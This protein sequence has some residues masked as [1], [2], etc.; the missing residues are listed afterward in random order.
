MTNFHIQDHDLFTDDVAITFAAEDTW[1]IQSG[2]LV[3]SHSQSAIFSGAANGTLL[4]K[5]TILSGSESEAGVFFNGPNAFI[6]NAAGARIVG[7]SDGV[8]TNS[9]PATVEN[10]GV[11]E[12]LGG[13]GVGFVGPDGLLT[14][15][16]SVHGRFSG[17]N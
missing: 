4:N 10:H 12:G 8:F 6:S 11:I 5:G 15:S 3:V 2:V 17:V 16:G 13:D 1:T 9:D 7:A 14:N